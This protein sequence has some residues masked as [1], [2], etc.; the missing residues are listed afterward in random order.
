MVDG[1]NEDTF[2]E[3]HCKEFL[4]EVNEALDVD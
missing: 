1:C 4:T 3:L 2:N